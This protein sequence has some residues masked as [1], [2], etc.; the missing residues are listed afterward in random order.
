MPSVLT[1]C[2]SLRTQSFH[3]RLLTFAESELDRLGV[4]TQRLKNLRD[5]PRFDEDLDDDERRPELVTDLLSKVVSVD[6]VLLSTPTYNGSLPSAVKDVI[7]W[8]S[9]PLGAGPIRGRKIGLIAASPGPHG[10][11]PGLEYL[12]RVLRALGATV[13]KPIVALPEVHNAFGVDTLSA[14]VS[15]HILDVSRSVAL[16]AKGAEVVDDPVLQRFEIRTGGPTP[17]LLGFVDYRSMGDRIE[18]PHTVT[19]PEF[20]GQGVASALI[21][22]VL[23]RLRADEKQ[24]I[25][26]CWFVAKFIENNAEYQSML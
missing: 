4:A 3:N 24:V 18:L 19:Q 21:R 6:A 7:D 26:S 11:A 9:R 12:Q 22:E 17:A 10:G 1:I 13:I 20:E 23:D 2:G 16:A 15:R 8:C 25:P 5:L 14:A